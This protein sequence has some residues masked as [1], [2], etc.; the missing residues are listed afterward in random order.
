[1]DIVESESENDHGEGLLDPHTG[2]RLPREKM[3]YMTVNDSQNEDDL[4]K[5]SSITEKYKNVC[6]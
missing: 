3:V 2:G 5:F 4:G 6:H 1:M